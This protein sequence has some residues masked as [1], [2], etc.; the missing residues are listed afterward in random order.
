[1]YLIIHWRGA[2]NELMWTKLKLDG[3]TMLDRSQNPAKTFVRSCHAA[4]HHTRGASRSPTAPWPARSTASHQPVASSPNSTLAWA[5]S[6]HR[7]QTWSTIAWD[8]GGIKSS[9][10]PAGGF[11]VHSSRLAHKLSRDT[12]IIIGS[13]ELPS[14]PTRLSC[15][16]QD[17]QYISGLLPESSGRVALAPCAGL[18]GW[19]YSGP[20]TSFCSSGWFMSQDIWTCGQIYS[21][22]RGWG[23]KNRGCIPY[24]V[25]MIWQRF[26]RVDTIF[27]WQNSFTL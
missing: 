21:W 14:V 9:S 4:K 16:G 3:I 25:S 27:L 13:Q 5:H 22:G 18:R 26:G 12:S 6:N 17:R 20:I 15:V 24:V 10:G 19:F 7:K 2:D 11:E 23:S 8:T 1:M